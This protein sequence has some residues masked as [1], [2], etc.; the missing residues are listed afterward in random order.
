[1][2][3][4]LSTRRNGENLQKSGHLYFEAQFAAGS[5]GLIRGPQAVLWLIIQAVP[6]EE[7]PR[8]L[9]YRQTR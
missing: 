1:M 6:K 2:Y 9:A 7:T 3:L 5:S 4:M 8:L